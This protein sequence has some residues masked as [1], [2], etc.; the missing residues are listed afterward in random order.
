MAGKRARTKGNYIYEQTIKGVQYY[1]LCKW[2]G[3]KRLKEYHRTK[4]KA[5]SRLKELDLS[6][7]N[8]TLN[9][10]ALTDAQK[11][12][13]LQASKVAEEANV[14][15]MD[16]VR[17]AGKN[18]GGK[19]I[20]A[21][22]AGEAYI[23]QLEEAGVE[24]LNHPRA[25]VQ[26]FYNHFGDIQMDEVDP[27]VVR[28]WV[29][30][31]KAWKSPRTKNNKLNELA[32]WWRFLKREGYAVGERNVFAAPDTEGNQGIKRHKIPAARVDIL[33]V[34]EAAQVL[35]QAFA[36]PYT[37][38]IVVLVL[39]CGVRTQE[40]CRLTMEDIDLDDEDPQIDIP[41]E[42]AKKFRNG[43]TA[44]RYITLTAFQV[45]WLK[46]AFEA[47][48]VL[49]VDPNT[50]QKHKGGNREYE[51]KTWT[52][53]ETGQTKTKTIRDV[54]AT[55]PLLNNRPNVLRHTYCS[56]HLCAF[57]DIGKT[58][59]YAGNSPTVIKS[60]YLERVKP[61]VAKRFWNIQPNKKF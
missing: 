31:N 30:K 9:W 39:L 5:G 34:E 58:S 54:P 53:S 57:E 55:I 40:A 16:V 13:V 48:G 35:E 20:G 23:E 46:A 21:R 37:A 49:P 45:G 52:V 10:E 50:Y 47:G 36:N 15:L 3:G 18:G 28:K 26:Q 8:Q 38:A 1:V 59:H 2:V 17:V 42:K 61:K 60:N 11:I 14:D 51:D 12:T 29:A 56:Y 44:A 27:S 41:P 22:E 33:T 7:Q 25:A 6:R 4:L 32:S 24:H 19:P 43:K